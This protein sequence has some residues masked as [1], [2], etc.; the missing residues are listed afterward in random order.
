[1]FIPELMTGSVTKT[2]TAASD[3]FE[4]GRFFLIAN[5]TGFVS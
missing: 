2:S 3:A 1:L 4:S 5:P